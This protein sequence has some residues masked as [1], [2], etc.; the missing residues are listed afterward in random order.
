[1]LLNVLLIGI[2]LAS[3]AYIA[4]ELTPG[5]PI[6]APRLPPVGQPPVSATV[7]ATAA[8]PSAGDRSVVA[9]RNLFS[10]TRTEVTLALTGRPGGSAPAPTPNLYGV[11]LRDGAP[12]AY[13]E[14]PATKRVADYRTGD[15]VAGGTVKLI[16]ADRVILARPEGPVEVR[17]NDRAKPG[18]EATPP[19]AAS[20]QI[21]P[22][23]GGVSQ[24]GMPH[25]QERRRPRE[26]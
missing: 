21:S 25:L 8:S 3:V 24:P 5:T 26:E 14:D 16:T 22:P 13:L 10:P 18:P 11:V 2:S 23:P 15:T 12:I 1:M 9:S 7:P 4:R 19:P 20:G 17:L 6:S